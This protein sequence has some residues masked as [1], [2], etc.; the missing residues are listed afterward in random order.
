MPISNI[1]RVLDAADPAR[2][3]AKVPE[4]HGYVYKTTTG[5]T[6]EQIAAGMYKLIYVKANGDQYVFQWDGV[7]DFTYLGYIANNSGDLG[8]GAPN[9]ETPLVQD[10]DL[11]EAYAAE[12][13]T[14][15][16]QATY[17]SRRTADSN[18]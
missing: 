10:A 5:L 9:S 13:W 6:D 11:L 12:T 18:W 1:I 16:A 15:G 14:I 3:A 17:E 7:A 4:W 8:S 2:N